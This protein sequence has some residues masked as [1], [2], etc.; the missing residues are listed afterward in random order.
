LKFEEE[1]NF[2]AETLQAIT[3]ELISYPACL[4]VFHH[5][6]VMTH[7]P[8]MGCPT[9]CIDFKTSILKAPSVTEIIDF[10]F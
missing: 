1:K 5:H 10:L 3:K 9:N 6:F 7:F 8:E 2:D 4:S